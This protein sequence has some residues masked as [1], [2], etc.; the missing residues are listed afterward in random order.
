MLFTH[1]L[2]CREHLCSPHCGRPQPSLPSQEA[3]QKPE[4]KKDVYYPQD[5][6][7]CPHGADG[8]TEA[9]MQ[10]NIG[11]TS[12]PGIPAHERFLK[13]PL[14][15]GSDSA[16]WA[17][18]GWVWAGPGQAPWGIPATR[19]NFRRARALARRRDCA[20]ARFQRRFRGRDGGSKGLGGNELSPAEMKMRLKMADRPGFA[21]DDSRKSRLRL[22]PEAPAKWQREASSSSLVPWGDSRGAGGAG[23]AF[24]RRRR[25]ERHRPSVR[26][27]ALPPRR[28]EGPCA[29]PRLAPGRVLES[30]RLA[31]KTSSPN[32]PALEKELTFGPKNK[33]N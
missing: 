6:H 18:P 12:S 27:V 22:E 24:V 30:H 33:L 7:C 20:G 19:A 11:L 5:R 28:S 32:L 4:W 13:A 10:E 2:I 23:K 9:Q 1:R 21:A 17:G 3:T 26:R 14:P 8:E 16:A 25:G 29:A 15:R 31:L